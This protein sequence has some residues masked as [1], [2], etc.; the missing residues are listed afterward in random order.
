MGSGVSSVQFNAGVT[1]CSERC[2]RLF[3]GL[4]TDAASSS[5]GSHQRTALRLSLPGERHQ[6]HG[7]PRA[8]FLRGRWQYSIRLDE[9]MGGSLPPPVCGSIRL[10]GF[11]DHC[12]CRR[13]SA[14]FEFLTFGEARKLRGASVASGLPSGATQKRSPGRSWRGW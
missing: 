6:V 8:L 13:N 5:H 9:G 2:N 1:K 10:Q 11:A 12:S 7:D 3:L 14:P 4:Q